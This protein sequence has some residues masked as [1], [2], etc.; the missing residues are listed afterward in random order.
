MNGLWILL[1]LIFISALP[2]LA[3]L[4]WIHVRRFPIKLLWFLL[5]L[6]GGAFSLGIAAILQ[7]LFPKTD[8]VAI[9][10]LLFKIFIQIALTEEISRL[11]VFF[12]LFGLFRRFSKNTEAY[13]PAFCAITGLIAGLGFAVIETAMYGVGNFSIALVRAVTAAPLHGACGTRIGMAAFHIKD[14]PGLALIRFLYVVGI[15]G[16]YNFMIL[17]PGIPLGFPVLIAFIALLSS[18]QLIR[19]S[20]G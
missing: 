20:G 3:V 4:I 16:M 2:V 1:L 12:L 14:A 15:H 18:I 8:E 11:G 9:G 5:A 10:V 13:V 19:Y 6:L 7:S 17:H